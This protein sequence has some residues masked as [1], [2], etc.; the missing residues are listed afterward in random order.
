MD[1]D[2]AIDW[3]LLRETRQ[4][5]S[6]EHAEIEHA[7]P[8]VISHLPPAL[9][10]NAPQMLHHQR[11][12]DVRDPFVQPCPLAARYHPRIVSADKHDQLHS[13][14]GRHCADNSLQIRHA[15]DVPGYIR[16]S[17]GERPGLRHEVPPDLGL[18]QMESCENPEQEER[19]NHAKHRKEDF[20]TERPAGDT[21]HGSVRESVSPGRSESTP[22]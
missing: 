2:G 12:R 20:A 8:F 21:F 17:R 4:T 9:G 11:I 16:H 10:Q 3:L 14:L 18:H 5:Q 15:F 13:A 22:T 7:F 19:R 1:H 6:H